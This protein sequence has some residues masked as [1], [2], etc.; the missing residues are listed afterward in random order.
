MCY[1]N[2][3]CGGEG[4]PCLEDPPKDEDIEMAKAFWEDNHD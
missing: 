2:E 3:C 4:A 1:V